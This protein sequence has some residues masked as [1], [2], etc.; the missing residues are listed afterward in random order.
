MCYNLFDKTIAEKFGLTERMVIA[1][2]KSLT[3]W[4]EPSPLLDKTGKFFGN[5]YNAIVSA[6]CVGQPCECGGKI[7][8][9]T[10]HNGTDVTGYDAEIVG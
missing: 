1:E 6:E 10:G 5:H 2:W 4:G 7:F 3:E 9:M 8:I